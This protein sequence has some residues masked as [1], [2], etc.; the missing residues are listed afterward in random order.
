MRLDG[1]FLVAPGYETCC[2][3]QGLSVASALLPARDECT[4]GFFAVP[5]RPNRT[6]TL[7]FV[8]RLL[9]LRS[10]ARQDEDAQEFSDER[11]SAERAAPCVVR[12]CGGRATRRLA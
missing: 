10:C 3:S 1:V 8:C 2:G 9:R 4:G 5:A 11:V 12:A 7:F 6:S